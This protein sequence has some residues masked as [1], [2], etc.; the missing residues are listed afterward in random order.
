[1]PDRKFVLLKLE[2][3]FVSIMCEIN[4]EHRK[5]VTIENGVEVLYLRILKALYGMIESAPLWYELY[6]SVLKDMGFKLNPYDMCEENKNINDKQ[7]T[8]AWYVDN[9]KASH[10]DPKMVSAVIQKIEERFPGLT[11]TRGN[12]QTFIGIQMRF[13]KAEKKDTINMRDYILEAI[14][15]FG[16]EV[17]EVV[18]SPGANWLFTVCKKAKKLTG[19]ILISSVQLLQKYC[20]LYREGDRIVPQR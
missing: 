4:P 2:G 12:K 16:E 6:V 13:M 9:N 14:E 5:Y 11:I 3:K 17:S 8:I 7:C 19:K 20:G 18:S 15:D 1:M 10:V